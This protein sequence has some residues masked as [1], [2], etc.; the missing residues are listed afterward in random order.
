MPRYPI[1]PK[2]TYAQGHDA[3]FFNASSAV[4]NNG[5]VYNTATLDTTSTANSPFAFPTYSLP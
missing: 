5:N 4:G 3:F 1:E 2:F